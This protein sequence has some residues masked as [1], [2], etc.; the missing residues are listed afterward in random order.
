[1]NRLVKYRNMF[2]Q[3][4]I[5]IVTLG[6]YGIYWYYQTCCEMKSLADDHDA[7]PVLWTILL[8]IPF[9][10]MYSYYKHAQLFEKISD[11]HFNRWILFILWI[12]FSPVV[13]V[14]VQIE[15]NK[16]TTPVVVATTQG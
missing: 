8:F 16:K 14:I 6:I 3:V 10:N 13:W 12:V 15:L 11:E 4:L 9:A 7:E 5:F 2:L 1:M